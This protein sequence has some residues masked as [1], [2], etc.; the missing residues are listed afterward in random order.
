MTSQRCRQ[1]NKY[2]STD[3]LRTLPPAKQKTKKRNN[4][5][6]YFKQDGKKYMVC[7][8]CYTRTE[9]VTC[10]CIPDYAAY[11]CDEHQ[12]FSTLVENRRKVGRRSNVRANAD[13][14]FDRDA[15]KCFACKANETQQREKQYQRQSA[16][17][18]N[19]ST[20][21]KQ[22]L[23]KLLNVKST[24]MNTVNS[25]NFGFQDLTSFQWALL[26]NICILNNFKQLHEYTKLECDDI[27]RYLDISPSPELVKA[28]SQDKVLKAIN[29]LSLHKRWLYENY[30]I[31]NTMCGI[32]F[33]LVLKDA[34]VSHYEYVYAQV[35]INSRLEK[36]VVRVQANFRRW[37]QHRCNIQLIHYIESCLVPFALNFFY[38]HTTYHKIYIFYFLFL[39]TQSQVQI[40]HCLSNVSCLYF[41]FQF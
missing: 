36:L 24:S 38:F 19:L 32:F 30:H 17:S 13:M 37:K 35:P 34:G 9:C 5:K 25:R 7:I 8:E 18:L 23:R 40:Y 10:E 15:W 14:L 33:H 6:R 1:C 20:E 3:D 21:K 27:A 29:L 11:C 39:N 22:S 28:S 4:N 2:T 41:L 31:P 12:I 16:V 26:W